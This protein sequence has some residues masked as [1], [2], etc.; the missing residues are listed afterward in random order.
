MGEAAHVVPTRSDLPL[1]PDRSRF[2][3][4]L[5]RD[6]CDQGRPQRRRLARL[7]QSDSTGWCR[8]RRHRQGQLAHRDLELFKV[9]RQERRR[10]RSRRFQP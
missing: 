10:R 6:Q 1:T 2:H 7:G 5:R 8:P 3:D 9:D 4:L